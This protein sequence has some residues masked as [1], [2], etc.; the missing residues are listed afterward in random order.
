MLQINS[1]SIIVINL[2]TI[3]KQAAA[4]CMCIIVDIVLCIG[5]SPYTWSDLSPG[6]HRLIVEP[7]RTLGCRRL[8]SRF[9]YFTIN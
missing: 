9:M 3:D 7:Y 8:Q 2:I 6:P 5:T 1:H 4:I